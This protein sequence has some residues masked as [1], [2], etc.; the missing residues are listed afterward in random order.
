[1]IKEFI[2]YWKNYDLKTAWHV[3]KHGDWLIEIAEDGEVWLD[4]LGLWEKDK[5]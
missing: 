2:Y 4:E 5:N 3:L 1:M